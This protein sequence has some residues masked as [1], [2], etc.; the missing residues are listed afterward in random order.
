[1]ERSH[2]ITSPEAIQYVTFLHHGPGLAHLG[3]CY[4]GERAKT[5]EDS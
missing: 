1:M 2:A 3:I 4:S 5:R